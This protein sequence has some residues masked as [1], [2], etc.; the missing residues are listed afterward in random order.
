MTIQF[1]DTVP[2]IQDKEE[3]VQF[4]ASLLLNKQNVPSP[5]EIEIVTTKE[6]TENKQ[7]YMDYANFLKRKQ[8]LTSKQENEDDNSNN[9]EKKEES[10]PSVPPHTES[11]E[12]T[13]PSSTD[14]KEL[15]EKQNSK[16]S[17]TA[18]M[19]M[20]DA[21]TYFC[22]DEDDIEIEPKENNDTD[23]AAITTIPHKI[24]ISPR[25]SNL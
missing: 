16:Q 22:T 14:L 24:V 6:Y 15:T 10:K 8:K 23:T 21:T 12:S 4:P 25:S 13:A 19:S 2:Y 5:L 9:Q 3:L 1:Y 18:S 7:N 17:S 11:P 20:C